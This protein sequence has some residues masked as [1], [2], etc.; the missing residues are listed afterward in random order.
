MS[1]A[2]FLDSIKRGSGDSVY[3][4]DT[5]FGVQ[6]GCVFQQNRAGEFVFCEAVKVD[7]LL[8]DADLKKNTRN[9]LS[10][11]K[12][13]FE[14]LSEA[15]NWY[16]NVS[17]NLSDSD[18]Q[19]TKM[20]SLF[21]NTN[22]S[23]DSDG[24]L[25]GQ[26]IFDKLPGWKQEVPKLLKSWCLFTDRE[27]FRNLLVVV[28]EVGERIY[29]S[30]TDIPGNVLKGFD[31]D[32]E[33]VH[34]HMKRWT[35]SDISGHGYSYS[36]I[37]AGKKI[38]VQPESSRPKQFKL[39]KLVSMT[40]ITATV[41][42]GWDTLEASNNFSA[43]NDDMIDPKENLMTTLHS[44]EEA[45]ILYST[46]KRIKV[47]RNEK[48]KKIFSIECFMAK[49]DE[50]NEAIRKRHSKLFKNDN[51]SFCPSD[52]LVKLISFE[53]I[54]SL[55]NDKYFPLPKNWLKNVSQILKK[56]EVKS[57]AKI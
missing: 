57:I 24:S 20:L 8:S 16:D 1:F 3:A 14:D 17:K 5:D 42:E 32:D 6:R 44:F 52:D 4:N 46:M 27:F 29:G 37:V 21:N 31:L 7:V 43:D 15:Q 22:G 19:I 48:N 51:Y 41:G 56:A 50:N 11:L 25:V 55:K 9:M 38:T 36:T 30:K 26:D 18:R 54:C 33:K 40:T 12:V 28:G 49:Y 34:A 10:L 39:E 53:F 2:S 23:G 35:S 45:N 13:L 47:T